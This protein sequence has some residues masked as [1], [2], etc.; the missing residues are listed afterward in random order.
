[1]LIASPSTAA[2]IS[3]L[4]TFFNVL[5][6]YTELKKGFS[7]ASSGLGNWATGK[8]A[9]NSSIVESARSRARRRRSAW[10]CGGNNFVQKSLG[11]FTCQARRQPSFRHNLKR[12][13][14]RLAGGS[15]PFREQ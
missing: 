14:T 10:M 4:L 6:P 15:R 13:G 8:G 11:L 12:D 2:T 1:M 3:C 9:R 5:T 7:S